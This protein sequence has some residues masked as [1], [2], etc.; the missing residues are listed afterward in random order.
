MSREEW[1][2]LVP[3]KIFYA[4]EEK[5]RTRSRHFALLER[6]RAVHRHPSPPVLFRHQIPTG[7]HEKTIKF[8]SE[9]DHLNLAT[10]RKERLR[11]TRPHPI[12]TPS[13]G[14]L[15]IFS[16]LSSEGRSPR[17]GTLI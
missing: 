5:D 14:D 9:T 10:R 12:I 17:L 3:H 16:S 8:D 4:R 2:M 6:I 11:W 15:F 7:G 13:Q 1:S